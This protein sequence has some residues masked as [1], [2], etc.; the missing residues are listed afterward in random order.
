M[1]KQFFDYYQ[2]LGLP[3]ESSIDGIMAAYRVLKQDFGAQTGELA[4]RKSQHLDD[5]IDVLCSADNRAKYDA[6]YF[7]NVEKVRE[8]D[9][10]QYKD[11]SKFRDISK[12]SWRDAYDLNLAT[13]Q[14]II[15]IAKSFVALPEPE[16]QYPVLAAYLLT[17]AALVQVIP[18][19]FASGV[20]GSG[21]T[22]IGKLAQNIWGVKKILIGK[23]TGVALRNDIC[24]LKYHDPDIMRYEKLMHG[25]IYDDLP[26]NQ[27]VEND[28][29]YAVMK[30]RVD[31]SAS[32]IAISGLD[33][34][35]NQEFDVFGG[36]VFSSIHPFDSMADYSELSR[37]ILTIKTA[38]IEKAEIILPESLSW[39]GLHSHCLKLWESDENAEKFSKVYASFEKSISKGKLPYKSHHANISGAILTTGI[40][41]G[42]WESKAE[43]IDRLGD[44][45][46]WIGQKREYHESATM[47]EIKAFLDKEKVFA[48]ARGGKVYFPA[49]KLSNHLD[50]LRREAALDS[51]VTVPQLAE[52]MKGLGFRLI[53]GVWEKV[54]E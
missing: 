26:A 54:D 28:Y 17:P 34:G 39:V 31:R 3:I 32:T 20:S 25:L 15:S 10:P 12:E 1:T 35:K 48:T 5:A 38:L 52:T 11:Y 42:I 4:K 47:R 45:W 37:R 40:L 16:L 13:G 18:V 30:G 33:K 51:N 27:F 6:E 41:S 49:V 8:A 19:L 7:E 21:K 9:K 50:N 23:T 29:S 46:K 53:Q 14:L 22:R 44:Y 24:E 43:A 36:C 2:L